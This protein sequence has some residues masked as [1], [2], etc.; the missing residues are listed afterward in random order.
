MSI[1]RTYYHLVWATHNRLPLI[2]EASEPELYRRITTKC[3]SMECRLYAIGGIADHV[4][5]VVSIPPKLAVAE[6]ARQIKGSSSRFMNQHHLGYQFAWQREYGV[7]SLGS[8]QLDQAITYVQNQ[9]HHHASNTL[10][11]AIEPEIFNRN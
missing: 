1:W 5:L 10:L 11:R 8:K 7:F 4:H 3:E 6:F 9:K 2:S